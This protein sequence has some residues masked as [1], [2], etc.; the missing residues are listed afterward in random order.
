MRARAL[1]LTAA[2]AVT[3]GVQRAEAACTL[4]SQSR[5]DETNRAAIVLDT[6][7]NAQPRPWTFDGSG[8]V[9][10][11]EPGLTVWSPPTLCLVEGRPLVVVGSYDHNVYALDALTGELSWKL[12]TGAPVAG[13]PVLGRVGDRL[14]LAVASND[15]MVYVLD[16][17]LGRQVWVHS[18][19]SY[20]PTLGG[21]QLPSPA[22][23]EA[24]GRPVL[25]VPFWVWDRSLGHNLQRAGVLALD[26]AEG[27][28][29]W[30]QELGDN[31]LTAP[32]WVRSRQGNWLFVGSGNGN[33]YALDADSGRVLWS[34]TELDA[35]RSPPAF[36][37]GAPG[38]P[39]VVTASKFGTVRGLEAATGAERWSA[40]T[41]DRVTGS[42]ALMEH[43]GRTLA[44]VGSYD[45]RL[46]AIDTAD[47]Q[48]RWSYTARGGLYSSPAVADVARRP[49]VLAQAWDNLLHVVEPDHGTAVFTVFTGRPLWNVAGMDE[50]NWSSPAVARINGRVMAYIGSYD[51]TLRA[52]PLDESGRS[53]PV[54]RSNGWF[55][56]SF[57]MSLLPLAALAI[58]LTRRQRR[59]QTSQASTTSN[60]AP[61]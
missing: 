17:A 27:K 24:G 50:S 41:G 30:R 34:K 13:G 22:F 60:G 4:W 10:G 15:R 11:Y 14:L 42:P 33:V 36:V 49:L 45:R 25:F 31:Q 58:H 19:E 40:K 1:S 26:A 47:G 18:V 37:A 57:P 2:L 8:R 59:R 21:A 54:L 28:P 53:A 48:V 35:V 9:W 32:V 7:S 20:R 61:A 43:D 44:L 46:H 52:L 38:G 3:A 23:G 6:P 5:C 39:L 29:V 12:S 16:P 55:W 51:G 56:A